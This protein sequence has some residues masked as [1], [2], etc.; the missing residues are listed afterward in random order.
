VWGCV[1]ITNLISE[2]PDTLKKEK[3]I[4]K[5]I[6]I[7]TTRIVYEYFGIYYISAHY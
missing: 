5:N 7:F 4:I 3:L 1:L 6:K 2:A